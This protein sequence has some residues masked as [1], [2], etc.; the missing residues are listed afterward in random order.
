M[1]N[2]VQSLFLFWFVTCK[3]GTVFSAEQYKSVACLNRYLPSIPKD[4]LFYC[5]KQ[6]LILGHRG[7]GKKFQENTIEGIKSLIGTGAD[8]FEADV[9]L[10]NY[11]QLV[12]FHSDNAKKLTGKDKFIWEMT[13]A[14]IKTLKYKKRL[15]YGKQ[16]YNYDKERPV[17]Q[18]EDL[19]RAMTGTDMIIDLEMKSMSWSKSVETGKAVAKL[20]RKLGLEKK[21]LLT[22][23]D[24]FKLLAAKQE[25]PNLA[26]GSYY[27]NRDWKMDS[28]SYSN[29]KQNLKALPGLETCLDSLPNNKSLMNFL[30]QTGSMY[31][32][33][34]AS[35]VEFQFGL[36]SNTAVMT[37]PLKTLKDNYNKKLTFGA[38]TIYNMASTESEI[39]ATE[40]NVQNLIKQ[41]AARLITD[42]VPRLMKK[43][44][45]QKVSSVRRNTS[46]LMNVIIALGLSIYKI[47]L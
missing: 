4:H 15:Q 8:G 3:H 42:D 39:N 44:G 23:L 27:L 5:K 34:N 33:L 9:V 6:P 12:L 31:K 30:F 32:A 35:F 2:V 25:N 43:L 28:Q 45:R 26:T 29:L 22:S 37:N 16:T 46:S 24:P 20:I 40:S 13:P 17:G 18:L 47:I 1:V 38:S 7:Q 11:G 41:G 21:V 19:F 36:F 14:E 10:T